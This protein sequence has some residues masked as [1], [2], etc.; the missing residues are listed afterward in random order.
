[1]QAV[2]IIRLYGYMDTNTIN[3]GKGEEIVMFNI[4]ER[5]YTNR[6]KIDKFNHLSS[7]IQLFNIKMR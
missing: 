3:K 4:K 5:G 2:V 1:M 7:K 6:V